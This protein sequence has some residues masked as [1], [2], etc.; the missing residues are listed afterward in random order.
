M[1]R[2]TNSSRGLGRRQPRW[3]FQLAQD[4]AFTAV[5][6]CV[7]THQ[8]NEILKADPQL[9]YSIPQLPRHTTL[10]GGFP[11]RVAG[12][13]VGAIGVSGGHYEQDIQIGRESLKL[14]D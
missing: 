3:A 11:I 2:S 14:I 12:A 6:F 10:G 1:R 8:W 4:K 7:P 5:S 13:V 9:I